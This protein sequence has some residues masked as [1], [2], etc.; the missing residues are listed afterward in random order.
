MA[1]D[2]QNQ[3][4]GI[5]ESVQRVL[6]GIFRRK[7]LTGCILVSAV[8]IAGVTTFLLPEQYESGMK[9]LV[10]SGRVDLLVSPDARNSVP[11]PN[12]VTE[13]QVNSEIELLGSYELLSKVVAD[14]NLAGQSPTPRAT[15]EA[16]RKL[17]KNLKIAPIRKADIIEVTYRARSPQVA[18]GVLKEVAKNYLD[19]HL[20]VHRSAGTEE[21]FHTQVARFQKKLTDYS[22]KLNSFSE[23]NGLAS[24]SEQKEL[25]VRKLLD[26]ET[27]LKEDRLALAESNERL[28]HLRTQLALQAPRVVTQSRKLPNQY[29]VE[30]LNTM[31]AELANRRVQALMKFQ[32]GDRVVAE[33]DDEIAHT[34]AALDQAGRTMSTEQ[35]SDLNPLHTTL[36]NDLAKEELTETGLKV[37]CN[38]LT[39]IIA[40]YRNRL[41]EIEHD[42]PQYEELERNR[43]ES[44]QNYLL[45]ARKQEEA[46]IA[47]SLDKQKV[48]NVALAEAP[49]EHHLPVR[50]RV[51]ISL[52]IGLAFACFLSVGTALA[53]EFGG[54]RIYT[55]AEMDSTG[56]YVL[57]TV[58]CQDA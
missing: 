32:A 49:I 35:V 38:G 8:A 21:F 34:K 48:A 45:Y 37:R 24:I 12:Q 40:S 19:V 23:A 11:A 28:S 50:P 43:K 39:R 29:S 41:A 9:F 6:A 7:L 53:L 13:S 20:R 31:L 3:T 15:E 42:S 30:R 52:L 4:G 16:V 17:K 57:A 10:K 46:R 47:D 56:L 33:I 27:S 58:P 18:A 2:N 26:A 25:L 55:P 1:D 44:E 22:S 14:C 54:G 36:Q 5:G 51:E